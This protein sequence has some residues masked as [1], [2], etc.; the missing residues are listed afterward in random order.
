MSAKATEA[1]RIH[2]RIL[3]L[4]ASLHADRN[5]AI[6]ELERAAELEPSRA[7]LHDELGSL[8]AQ[9]AKLDEA[10]AQFSAALRLKPDYAQAKLH[11]G[12][13]RWQQKSLDEALALLQL[14]V[15]LDQNNPQSHYYLAQIGRAHV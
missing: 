8:L 6:T 11:L 2:G 13:I 1:H 10:A 9:N 3:S 7:D 4:H 12:V 5:A 15:Q 14:A